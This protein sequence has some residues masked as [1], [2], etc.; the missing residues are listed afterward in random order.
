[1]KPKTPKIRKDKVL[2]TNE[3]VVLLLSVLANLAIVV[4]VVAL[5][6][7]APEWLSDH[8][9]LHDLARKIQAAVILLVVALPL[10]PFLRRARFALIQEN[11]IHLGHD[12]MAHL[13]AILERQARALGMAQ[14]PELYISGNVGPEVAKAATL[15]GGRQ[16]IVLGANVFQG[17]DR[18]ENRDDVYGFILGHEMGRLQLGHATWWQELF[19]GYLK[20]IPVLR[21]PLLTVQALARDRIAAMLAPDGIRGLMMQVSGGDLLEEVSVNG[22]V[23]DAMAGPY[24]WSRLATFGRTGP[25]I[26]VR[27]RALYNQGYFKLPEPLPPRSEP[28]HEEPAHLTH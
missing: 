28:A 21:L 3:K 23:R 5:I 13:Y 6:R 17:L 18:G 9:R 15:V 8:P 25:H 16:V 1:V 11:S 22:F 4:S 26:A 10:V 2:S 7:I 14:V 12:Q 27:V 19:L 24:P 20:R